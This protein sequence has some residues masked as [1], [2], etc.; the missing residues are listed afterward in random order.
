MQEGDELATANGHT[1]T[2][3]SVECIHHDEPVMVYNIAVCDDHTYFVGENSVLVHNMCRVAPDG[4]SANGESSL[5]DV[6]NSI[7]NSPNY[8]EGFETVPNGTTRNNI[9]NREL[10]EEL[11][12]VE[13]GSWKKVYKDGYDAFG[14]EVSVHYFQSQSGKVFNV[15]VKAGWSN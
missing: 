7:K 8:P 2:V 5:R 3:D 4:A 11:R 1:A 9:N 6:Y 10:L 13:G 14:N 15:K 12:K